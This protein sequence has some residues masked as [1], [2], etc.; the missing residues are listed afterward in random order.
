MGSGTKEP[1]KNLRGLL[2]AWKIANRKDEHLVLVGPAG[3]GDDIETELRAAGRV[4]SISFVDRS[5]LTA[6]YAGASAFCW[7]SL[8]EGFGFPV[9]E[10]MA[11]GCPVITSLGTSTEEIVGDAGVLVDP[12]DTDAI[13]T[14]LT[15]LL[16]DAAR[17]RDLSQ[18]GRA[19][20]AT[21]SW[22][23]TAELLEDAYRSAIGVAA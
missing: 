3:W 9:L 13:A 2:Q 12:R 17:R 14:A 21:Y 1:R 7:P 6:L 11:Q 20:A 8:R 23:R 16:D 15:E 4:S 5:T 10:A 19:R 18:K 22:Q